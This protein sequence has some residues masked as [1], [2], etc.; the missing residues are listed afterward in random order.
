[1]LHPLVIWC[2][3][4][5][6][7]Y[8]K[9]KLRG[10][11]GWKQSWDRGNEDKPGFALG[12]VSLCTSLSLKWAAPRDH[13]VLQGCTKAMYKRSRAPSGSFSQTATLGT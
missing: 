7:L 9:V 8:A 3:V 13:R 12:I 10:W 11:Q 1:M 5:I 6:L 4:L 2:S